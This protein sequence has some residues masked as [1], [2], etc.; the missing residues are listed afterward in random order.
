M[1]TKRNVRILLFIVVLGFAIFQTYQL[2]TERHAAR[3]HVISAASDAAQHLMSAR[4]TIVRM[5]KENEWDEPE[6]REDLKL[7]LTHTMMS[8]Q[9]AN[10]SWQQLP[11]LV[12]QD[13]RGDMNALSNNFFSWY[14]PVPSILDKSG[15]LTEGDKDELL[16]LSH[17][18]SKVDL[19]STLKW[20]EVAQMIHQAE[21][22][23]KAAGGE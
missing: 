14:M 20:D 12:P 5:D 17:I 6:A 23:W 7:W 16:Y 2:Q 18:L 15:P 22:E 19:Y 11:Y 8:L 1:N 13:S 10:K 21:Q 4:N 3:K 9:S